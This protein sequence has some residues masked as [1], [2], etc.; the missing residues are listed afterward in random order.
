MPGDRICAEIGYLQS[1]VIL[2]AVA[3]PTRDLNPGA[4]AGDYAGAQASVALGDTFEAASCGWFTAR[5]GL[6]EKL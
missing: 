2:W 3:A 4:L 5:T 1:A 6:E